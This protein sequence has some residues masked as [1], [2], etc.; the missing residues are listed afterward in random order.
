MKKVLITGVSG[1]IGRFLSEYLLNQDK[2]YLVYGISRNSYDHGIDVQHS[3][4]DITRKAD[5]DACLREIKPDWIIHL[6][7]CNRGG[8]DEMYS[9]NV[10][11]TMNILNS[12]NEYCESSTKVLVIGSAAEYGD[13]NSDAVILNED[14]TLNPVSLYGHSKVFQT[15]MCKEYVKNHSSRIIIARPTNIIGVGQK[16]DFVCSAFAKQIAEIE[17]YQ[18]TKEIQVGNL[19]PKRDFIDVRDVV[20]ALYGMICSKHSG[21]LFNVCYGKETS[22]K[23]VLTYLI[24]L[25]DI[26]VRVTIDWNRV[27]K[28]DAIFQKYSYEKLNSAIGW[29][30]AIDI[31]SSLLDLLNYWRSKI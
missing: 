28:N 1:F 20:R 26:D 8:V 14:A 18:D 15:L 19:E 17:K 3:S 11:G 10:I 21:R 27:R 4:V 23:E 30:P 16:P 7:A 29:S 9:T 22:I 12:V 5:V 24:S 25:T 31:K 13:I 6:A 2:T